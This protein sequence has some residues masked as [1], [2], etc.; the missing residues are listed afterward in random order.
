M[1]Y[2]NLFVTKRFANWTTR[3]AL[4]LILAADFN[5]FIRKL[6]TTGGKI[7]CIYK[8]LITKI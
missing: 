4:K 3:N 5:K 7:C 8:I 6:R 1:F 2:A